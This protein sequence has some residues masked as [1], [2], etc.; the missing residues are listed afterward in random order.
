MNYLSAKS[1]I[2]SELDKL[3]HLLTYHGKHHTLDVLTVAERLCVAENMPDH[4]T[5]LILTAALFHDSGFLNHYQNHEMHSCT[6]A[7]KVL[8]QFDYTEGAIE[9]ICA[10]IMATKIPQTPLDHSAEILCDADLDYFHLK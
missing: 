10:M 9:Q 8:P 3:S 2:I 4:E 7:R 6:I 5:A 1:F